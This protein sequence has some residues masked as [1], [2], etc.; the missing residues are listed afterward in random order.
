MEGHEMKKVRADREDASY[1]AKALFLAET[2]T[3]PS[4]SRL[5]TA[6]RE[7]IFEQMSHSAS[8]HAG[9]DFYGMKLWLALAAVASRNGCLPPRHRFS[10]TVLVATA[11]RVADLLG[12]RTSANQALAAFVRE[13]ATERDPL[14]TERD[15]R[16]ATADA[17]SSINRDRRRI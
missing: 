14:V 9:A 11:S 17:R 10:E 6:K 15:L 4:S 7:R 16:E 2:M 12:S 3:A 13:H 5:L 1:L 8:E